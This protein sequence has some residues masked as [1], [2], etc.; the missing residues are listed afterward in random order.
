MCRAIPHPLRGALRDRQER[1]ER[2]AVDA[3]G[4]KDERLICV[5]RSRVVPA[6]RRWRQVG[7]DASLS[8]P[9]TG[10]RQ[11]VPRGERDISR[12]AT[13]QGCRTASAEP[14]CSCAFFV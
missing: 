6:P 10:A 4:P 2:D 11:P 7:E 5:R 12:K 9:M 14:V 1:W 3:D 8:T 13:A